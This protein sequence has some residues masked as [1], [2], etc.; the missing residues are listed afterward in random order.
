LTATNTIDSNKYQLA[1]LGSKNVPASE[2]A[3]KLSL[4]ET[5]VIEEGLIVA[6]TPEAPA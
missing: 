2:A 1:N 4:I 3:E 5:P 6:R